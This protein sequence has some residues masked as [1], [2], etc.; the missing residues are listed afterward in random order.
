MLRFVSISAFFIAS[1]MRGLSVFAFF[2]VTKYHDKKQL[3]EVG[4]Y[5][6]LQVIDHR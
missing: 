1:S 3:G 4:I 6:N 5:L 2:F